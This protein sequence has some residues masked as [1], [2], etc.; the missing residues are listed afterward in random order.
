MKNLVV[1][2]AALLFSFGINAQDNKMDNKMKDNKMQDGKMDMKK[3]HVMMKDGKMMMMKEGEGM[4][5]SGK[6]MKMDKNARF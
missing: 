1:L 5:M 4:D 2:A 3:D 6:M